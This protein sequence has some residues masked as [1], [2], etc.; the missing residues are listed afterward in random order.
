MAQM[1]PPPQAG[2]AQPVQPVVYAQ[3]VPAQ[4]VY[5]QPGAQPMY[6][7]P[8]QQ[9]IVINQAP[10]IKNSMQAGTGTEPWG[11]LCSCMDD[12]PGCLYVW[13]CHC[14]AVCD[15]GTMIGPEVT[16]DFKAEPA[17]VFT[18]CGSQCANMCTYVSVQGIPIGCLIGMCVCP[19]KLCC[20]YDANIMKAAAVKLNKKTEAPSPCENS[21]IVVMCL[22]CTTQCAFCLIYK[23]LKNANKVAPTG[24]PDV[25]EMKR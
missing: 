25:D 3:A 16:V 15:I 18:S 24:L 23:E 7:P 1:Y 12:C 17:P 21:A 14:C 10:P 13:C 8:V 9:T 4:P 2:Y 6:A 19:E 22:P 5:V 11:G 20:V